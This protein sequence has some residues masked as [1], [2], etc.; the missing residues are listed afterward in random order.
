MGTG[1]RDGGGGRG[2]ACPDSRQ[3]TDCLRGN[4]SELSRSPQHGQTLPVLPTL[5][6]EKARGGAGEEERD[7]ELLQ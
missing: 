2:K 6:S 3:I 7:R 5:S 4:H 1:G